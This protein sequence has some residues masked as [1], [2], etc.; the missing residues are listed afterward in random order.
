MHLP[1]PLPREHSPGQQ[2]ND[3]WVWDRRGLFPAAWAC[4]RCLYAHPSASGPL[5][6]GFNLST[7]LAPALP[8]PALHRNA[9]PES[10]RR[11]MLP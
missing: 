9:T 10:I 11:Q 4:A 5:C 1:F 3:R 6:P 8:P 2:V 7:V